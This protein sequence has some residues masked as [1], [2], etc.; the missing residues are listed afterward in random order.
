MY[1]LVDGREV[2]GEKVDVWEGERIESE[3]SD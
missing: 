3:K 2:E 1:G